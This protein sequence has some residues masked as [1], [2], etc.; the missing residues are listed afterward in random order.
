MTAAAN[1]L[2]TVDQ[3]PL[4]PRVSLRRSQ[5][6]VEITAVAVQ[7]AGLEEKTL[8]DSVEARPIL[9]CGRCGYFCHPLSLEASASAKDRPLCPVYMAKARVS[10]RQSTGG[11]EV[12]A[13]GVICEIGEGG[14]A[15]VAE[16]I[17]REKQQILPIKRENEA[18]TR[19]ADGDTFTLFSSMQRVRSLSNALV[20]RE[21]DAKT[22]VYA[23]AF[24]AACETTI[25]SPCTRVKRTQQTNTAIV[26][27]RSL[28]LS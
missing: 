13:L 6:V 11:G 18:R 28:F 12:A 15:V 8:R 25:F 26:Y 17:D 10:V 24:F 22:L 20:R 5:P 19:V 7:R 9:V 3:R 2:V 4:P 27:L 1:D 14:L 23:M 21:G 16:A